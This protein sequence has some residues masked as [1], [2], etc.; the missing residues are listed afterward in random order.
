VLDRHKPEVKPLAEVR[1]S[2]VT[3]L[4]KER[5]TGAALKAANA[6]R[7]KLQSGASFDEVVRDLKVSADP[8]RFVNRSDSSILPELRQAAFDSTRPT[9]KPVYQTVKLSNGGAAIMQITKVRVPPPPD[10]TQQAA[11][12]QQASQRDGM[13]E[14]NAYVDQVR[15][16]AKVEKNPK[17][18]E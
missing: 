17:A 10:K 7:D 2:I 1:E 8:A 15:R 6:A 11:S 14:A 5:G 16:N 3:A 12:A 13:S 9:A 4:T 18:F